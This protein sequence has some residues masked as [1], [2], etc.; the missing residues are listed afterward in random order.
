MQRLEAALLDGSLRANARL[1]AERELAARYA[2][3]R[4]TIREAI[5]RLAA[6]GLLRSKQGVGVFVTEQLRTGVTS[7]WGQLLSGHPGVRDDVL[8]FR[9]V[10]EGAMA[11]F[12][13]QR[14]NEE[15]CGRI[16]SALAQ[17]EGARLINDWSAEATADTRL[18]EAIAQASHNPMFLHLHSSVITMLRE[19]IRLN[20]NS[21]RALAPDVSEQLL[22]QHRAIC[23]AICAG[24]P[25]EARAAMHGHIDYVAAKVTGDRLDEHAPNCNR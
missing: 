2:V 12:A 5:Q 20:S 19:H 3:S 25:D 17:L 23:D 18:H 11:Y 15:D 9:H 13:A 22:A 21:L 1:P 14:S 16:R 7:P 24:R 6:R 10:M 4:N 8:E